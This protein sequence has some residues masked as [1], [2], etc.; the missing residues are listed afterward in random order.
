[1]V[2][3]VQKIYS[4]FQFF[5]RLENI[6]MLKHTFSSFYGKVIL[7]TIYLPICLTTHKHTHLRRYKC[8]STTTTTFPCFFVRYIF[9]LE[10]LITLKI[11]T[12]LFKNFLA[13]LHKQKSTVILWDFCC[14]CCLF[15]LDTLNNNNNN[16]N[17]NE[18]YKSKSGWFFS[19]CCCCCYYY[20]S[21]YSPYIHIPSIFI[22][23]RLLLLSI[24]IT[25]ITWVGM[26]VS[27]WSSSSSKTFSF[28]TCFCLKKKFKFFITK[29]IQILCVFCCYFFSQ[30]II[31]M[32]MDNNNKLNRQQQQQILCESCRIS[33]NH[34][35]HC[36][37]MLFCLVGW[38][39]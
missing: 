14:C 39:E 2:E 23:F 9:L 35:H 25:I 4:Y 33:K 1:M 6:I 29:K 13:S 32:I 21:I 34:H 10:S 36:S 3:K 16:N 18:H 19:I 27:I 12:F 31:D 5:F 26:P 15:T 30:N 22:G 24:I 20:S 38:L 37:W 7:V 28:E 17:K 8:V 11:I